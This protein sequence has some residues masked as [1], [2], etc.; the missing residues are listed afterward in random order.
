MDYYFK[1]LSLEIYLIFCITS[2]CNHFIVVWKA[3]KRENLSD[4][5]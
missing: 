4:V 5:I 1:S 2:I 3:I